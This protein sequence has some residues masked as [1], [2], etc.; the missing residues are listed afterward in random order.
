ME[1]M[2]LAKLEAVIE[3]ML[4][5]MQELKR[6]KATL[7]AQLESKNNKIADLEAQLRSLNS[8]QEEVGTRVTN[9]LSTIEE[10]E[11]SADSDDSGN[12]EEPTES[13]ETNLF[14]LG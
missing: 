10:W 9:L 1:G 7:Q 11:K 3:K 5:S 14:N 6:E 12:Q 8:N 13:K 4:N 2:N